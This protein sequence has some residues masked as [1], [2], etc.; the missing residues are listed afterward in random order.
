M[1]P[2]RRI[3]WARQ[4]IFVRQAPESLLKP[5]AKD[6][7]ASS[8]ERE[9]VTGQRQSLLLLVISVALV[10]FFCGCIFCKL[11]VYLEL[12]VKLSVF[13]IVEVSLTVFGLFSS[14]LLVLIAPCCLLAFFA[15]FL[16]FFSFS[17]SRSCQL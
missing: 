7:S 17:Y 4:R 9:K 1:W 10:L 6:A 12:G 16:P 8:Q 5:R 15:R 13:I 14:L 11:C 3:A 2:S